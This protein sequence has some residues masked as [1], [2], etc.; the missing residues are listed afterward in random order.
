MAWLTDDDVV[1]D[2]GLSAGEVVVTTPLAVVADGTLVRATIDGEAP[3]RRAA[4]GGGGGAPGD[5]TAA[6]KP[7]ASALR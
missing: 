1:V 3:P 6:G 5:L 2:E 4:G 7:A